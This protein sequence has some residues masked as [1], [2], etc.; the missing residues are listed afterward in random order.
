MVGDLLV[1]RRRLVTDLVRGFE[2][3]EMLE[4]V[5]DPSFGL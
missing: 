1:Q 4:L 3:A 5:W 2:L